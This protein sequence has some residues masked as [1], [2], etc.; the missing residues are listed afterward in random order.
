[1]SALQFNVGFTPSVFSGTLLDTVARVPC[2]QVKDSTG[3]SPR[4]AGSWGS[5]M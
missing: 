3:V 4:T 1:M 2:S 5:G